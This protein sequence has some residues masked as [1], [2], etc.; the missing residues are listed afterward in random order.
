MIARIQR[1]LAQLKQG[2]NS[3]L[4]PAQDPRE[5]F[6]YTCQHQRQ[7][8]ERVQTAL[9]DIVTSKNRLEAKA[10]Q[11]KGKLPQLEHQARLA[12]LEG[13]EDLARLALR[14]HHIAT[15]ELQTLEQQIADVQQEERRLS[16]AEERLAAQIEAFLATQEIIAAR[17]SA[18]ESQA[19]ISET[20]DSVSQE[21][22]DLGQALQKA[23][24]KTEHMQ[25]RASAIDRLIEE[26]ILE[27]PG[28]SSVND[29][30]PRDVAQAVEDRLEALKR[31][32]GADSGSE[33]QLHRNDASG[34]VKN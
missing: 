31:E 24:Q 14:W 16:L 1:L 13:R 34:R 19:H 22:S 7:L 26:G 12:L 23:E 30:S 21:L 28:V 18:A 2:L 20:L 5:T 6:A 27:V 4:A 17:Y 9:T 3:V 11:V 15:L 33:G 10:A 32:I 25:A 29:L 8:L